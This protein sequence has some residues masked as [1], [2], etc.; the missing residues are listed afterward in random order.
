MKLRVGCA[1]LAFLEHPL[2]A[3]AHPGELCD[4]LER[5]T[6]CALATRPDTGETVLLW[7]AGGKDWTVSR[8]DP[9]WQ[10]HRADLQ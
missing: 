1:Q 8:A 5:C 7:Q 10:R 6:R 9:Q 3:V 4:P 2:Y